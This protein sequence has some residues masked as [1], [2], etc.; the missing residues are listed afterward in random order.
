M[1]RDPPTLGGESEIRQPLEESAVRQL[2]RGTANLDAEKATEEHNTDAMGKFSW[3]DG[4]GVDLG[5]NTGPGHE[6]LGLMILK[7]RMLR[8]QGRSRLVLRS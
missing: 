1:P 5:L 8:V 2:R 4:L 3:R 6:P 7:K